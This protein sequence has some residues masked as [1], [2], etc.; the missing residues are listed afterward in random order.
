VA[1]TEP[2]YTETCHRITQIPIKKTNP[3]PVDY[4]EMDEIKEIFNQIDPSKPNGLRD[5]AL[6]LFLY[7]ANAGARVE[8]ASQLRLSWLTLTRPY[9]VNILG[10]GKRWR[11]CPLWTVT[12]EAILA[13]RVIHS[14]EE[15]VFL[16][17]FGSP[18]SRHGIFDIVRKY[19]KKVSAKMP[20]LSQKRISPHTIRHSTA[21]AYAAGRDRP[22]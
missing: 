18:L 19:T 4:L 20:Q 14:N 10:K 16:N 22:Q 5:H 21:N 17:R 3:K 8:E 1:R 6:L 2:R 11:V 7:N 15:H 12:G 9:K 13:E